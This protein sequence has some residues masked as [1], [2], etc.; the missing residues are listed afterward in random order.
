MPG[1]E[2]HGEDDTGFANAH[3][4]GHHPPADQP[5]LGQFALEAGAGIAQDQ[6]STKP[7]TRCRRNPVRAWD[8]SAIHGAQT[9]RRH[10]R[11]SARMRIASRQPLR[12]ENTTAYAWSPK[13]IGKLKIS[14]TTIA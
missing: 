2:H 7:D 8:I 4:H 6:S 3:R 13:T 5:D 10:A 14:A 11:F 1:A 12:R 9:R